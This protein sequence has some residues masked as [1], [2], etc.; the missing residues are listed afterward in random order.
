MQHANLE[1]IKE[2]GFVYCMENDVIFN[3]IAIMK[4][5]LSA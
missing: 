5:V 3:K 1:K 2:G 4:D